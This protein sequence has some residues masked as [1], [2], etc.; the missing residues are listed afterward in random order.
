VKGILDDMRKDG[1]YDKLFA[2]YGVP[3]F[4]EPFAVHGP[5]L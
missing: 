2:A 1:S 5:D 3:A 4:T